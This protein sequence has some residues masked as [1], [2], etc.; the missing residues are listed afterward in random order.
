MKIG[1]T[2]YNL[3]AVNNMTL[4]EF[5]EKAAKTSANPEG[6]YK[7]LKAEHKR[8]EDVEREKVE[9]EKKAEDQKKKDKQD[10][11]DGVKRQAEKA[12]KA[13]T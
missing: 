9:A 4:S 10:H 5:K 13:N 12:K 11:A 8:I 1:K 3:E 6:D 2:K 7:K